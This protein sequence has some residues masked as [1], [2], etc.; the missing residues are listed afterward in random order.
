M[1]TDNPKQV[2]IRYP[3][4]KKPSE[5]LSRRL[6]KK[7]NSPHNELI[8]EPFS[9][10]QKP[11]FHENYQTRMNGLYEAIAFGLNAIRTP[12]ELQ[13]DENEALLQII[14]DDLTNHKEKI[15]K[16]PENAPYLFHQCLKMIIKQLHIHAFREKSNEEIATIL[17]IFECAYL[18]IKPRPI[19]ATFIDDIVIIDKPQTSFKSKDDFE[20]EPNHAS[21]IE[22]HLHSHVVKIIEEKELSYVDI[23]K[24]SR[25]DRTIGTRNRRVE[26]VWT[27]KNDKLDKK[28]YEVN[29][30]SIP[31]SRSNQQDAQNIAN[32]NLDLEIHEIMAQFLQKNPNWPQEEPIPIFYLS[33][34]TVIPGFD[35]SVYE[36]KEKACKLI[37]KNFTFDHNGKKYRPNIIETNHVVNDGRHFKPTLSFPATDNFIIAKN[38]I[39]QAK[40]YK[41]K[42]KDLKPAHVKIINDAIECLEH[43]I[44][45]SYTDTLNTP[46]HNRELYIAT[47]EVIL[48]QLIDVPSIVSC[49]SC[50]DRAAIF[51]MHTIAMLKTFEKEEIE[52]S[53]FT[54]IPQSNL[55]EQF[56]NTMTAIF[57]S[58]HYQSLSELNAT[59]VKAIKTPKRYL[60][61]DVHKKIANTFG[62]EHSLHED[63][64]ASTNDYHKEIRAIRHSYQ[65]NIEH[66]AHE[67][68][69]DPTLR[70]EIDNLLDVLTEDVKSGKLKATIFDGENLSLDGGK[71]HFKVPSQV[72][73]MI[74]MLNNIKKDIAEG[75]NENEILLKHKG[76]KEKGKVWYNVFKDDLSKFTEDNTKGIKAYLKKIFLKITQRK[77]T[78]HAY[79]GFV[80]LLNKYGVQHASLHKRPS[81]CLSTKISSSTKKVEIDLA[82]TD[83][84][85]TKIEAQKF[86]FF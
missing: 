33:L 42:H 28:I 3:E 43:A 56:S 46:A 47:F 79:K 39:I 64:L 51:N 82:D 24:S 69:E 21:S 30:M 63:L 44:K 17:D 74:D 53:K 54:D 15:I 50:K 22:K 71:T 25:D 12:H 78:R 68:E 35:L 45:M 85:G 6:L 9:P 26:T 59:G 70:L 80:K 67:V 18:M 1:L 81:T 20:K 37:N 38:L 72:Y 75:K 23:T 34:V 60:P 77:S 83:P 40:K 27:I 49:V 31:G 4:G 13:M 58:G 14:K 57:C 73:K 76:T 5:E 61:D 48:C 16:N 7:L 65:S 8:L 86:G 29:N 11:N 52:F 36:Q 32:Y 55:R 19:I 2:I 62:K 84:M 41:D 66:L 10:E